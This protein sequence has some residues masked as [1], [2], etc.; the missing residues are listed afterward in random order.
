MTTEKTKDLHY[1]TWPTAWG[2]MGGVWGEK[3][4]RRI[5]LPHY[6]PDELLQLLAWEHPKATRDDKPFEPLIQLCRDYFNGKNADFAEILCDLPG[7]GTFAGIVYRKCRTIAY[8]Q[9]RSY[10]ALAEM[11]NKPDAARAV[12]TMMSKNAIPLVIPCHRVINTGG[13]LGGFSAPGGID[14]KKRMLDLEKR[15]TTGTGH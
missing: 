12:A 1:A 13:G 3:G 9:T 7:E 14:T 2:A 8:G 10:L 5:V 15:S 11:I 6:Q 4:L